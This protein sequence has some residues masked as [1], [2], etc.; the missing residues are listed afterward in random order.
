[1][2][3]PFKFRAWDTKLNH[4]TSIFECLFFNNPEYIVTQFTGLKDKNN[5]EIYEGDIIKWTDTDFFD[6][7]WSERDIIEIVEFINGGFYPIF[8]WPPEV[9][10]ENLVEVI[11]NIYQNPELLKKA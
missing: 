9:I 11:G 7:N 4:F 6:D 3:R 1:M 10:S 8:E 5:K 2:N